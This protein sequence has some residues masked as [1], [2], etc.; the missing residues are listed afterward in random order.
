MK[1][2]AVLIVC[3]LVLSTCILLPTI[4][5]E[6][7][8]TQSKMIHC[9]SG[10]IQPA[11]QNHNDEIRGIYEHIIERLEL[12][13]DPTYDVQ[14]LLCYPEVQ[15]MLSLIADNDSISTV[16]MV[17]SDKPTIIKS[18]YLT[19]KVITTDEKR[20]Q[21]TYQKIQSLFDATMSFDI[22]SIDDIY[23]LDIVQSLNISKD[24]LSNYYTQW[25][26]YLLDNPS[27]ARLFDPAEFDLVLYGIILFIC[28]LFYIF[29][30]NGVVVV[31]GAQFVEFYP[32]V[33]GVIESTL[34]GIVMSGLLC[35]IRPQLLR[36]RSIITWIAEELIFKFVPSLSMYKEGIEEMIS[37]TFALVLLAGYFAAYLYM[38]L[39]T[40][41]AGGAFSVA[42]PVVLSLIIY[43]VLTFMVRDRTPSFSV[44]NH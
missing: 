1:K 2:F 19:Q 34:F 30:F 22:D 7:I 13:E 36:N 38:P 8:L 9:G 25:Q 43:Y 18:L 21:E 11:P 32:I 42:I 27:V 35:E 44:L 12:G 40:F 17:F 29:V 26:T 5:S 3:L 28:L 23:A 39:L 31:F 4:T 37:S 16:D 33:V 20:Q 41:F 6:P 10:V 15:S 24:H 14:L